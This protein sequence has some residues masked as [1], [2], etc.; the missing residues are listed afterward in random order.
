MKDEKNEREKHRQHHTQKWAGFI[1][2]VATDMCI[3]Y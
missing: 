2:V 1:S 3:K